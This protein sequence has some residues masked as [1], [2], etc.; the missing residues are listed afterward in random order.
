MDV[1]SKMTVELLDSMGSDRS[2]VRAARVSTIG[3]M[4]K[5]T[6]EDDDSHGPLINFLM[7]NRHG[8]PFEHGSLQW[9]VKAPIFV[10]REFHR[11]RIGFSYN[12]MSGRYTELLPEFYSPAE[13]RPLTQTGKAGHYNFSVTEEQS[14][15]HRVK[16][17]SDL[18]AFEACWEEYT[19]QLA[20]GIPK[21]MARTVLP[22]ATYSQMWVTCNPR[23][24]MSFL[25]LRTKEEWAAYPSF[26]QHEIEAVARLMEADFARLYPLTYGAFNEFGRVSP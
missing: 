23:S 4:S 15:K 19:L 3:A 20:A 17:A 12:E 10:F 18:R 1:L 2:V 7:K 8:T 5:E 25:S 22:L 16:L 21:E 24:L 11:H 14:S 9:F 6:K 26:P 13:D